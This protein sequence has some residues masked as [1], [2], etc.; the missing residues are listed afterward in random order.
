MKIDMNKLHFDTD[1]PLKKIN[2]LP[3]PITNTHTSG[4]GHGPSSGGWIYSWPM[5]IDM[6][7]LLS[8]VP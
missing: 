7:G 4:R 8:H 1:Q 5:S 6:P 2:S 3:P